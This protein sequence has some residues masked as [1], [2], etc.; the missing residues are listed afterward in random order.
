MDNK[1]DE[2]D[3]FPAFEKFADKVANTDYVVNTTS[4][5]AQT[6]Q[7]ST[8]NQMR[9]EG[10]A[11]LM[12]DLRHL[13]ANSDSVE[14][15]ETKDGIVLII[16]NN[17][18]NFTITWELKSTI[19]SLDYDPFVEANS[20]DESNAIKASKKAAREKEKVDHQKALEAK[21]A[22]KLKQLERSKDLAN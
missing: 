14:M 21:R 9:K 19:K 11:A 17:P 8:R 2:A 12:A 5:G 3:Y 18:G 22:A 16:E 15:A 13:Y 1:I 20:F 4:A 7:Q 10:V 6:I